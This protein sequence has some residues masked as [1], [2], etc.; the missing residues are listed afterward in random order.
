MLPHT[1]TASLPQW[2][3]VQS[4]AVKSFINCSRTQALF[5]QRCSCGLVYIGLKKRPQFRAKFD[6]AADSKYE[7]SY[8]TKLCT[9]ALWL[10]NFI[11]GLRNKKSHPP[12]GILDLYSQCSWICCHEWKAESALVHGRKCI[13]SIYFYVCCVNVY[14]TLQSGYW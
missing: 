3:L 5:M 9:G 10:C 8:S 11:K 12:R 14:C 2:P 13:L 1:L 4:K 6:S 7:I